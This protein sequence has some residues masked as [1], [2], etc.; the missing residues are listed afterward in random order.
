M[1]LQMARTAGFRCDV[2]WIDG[3]VAVRGEFADRRVMASIRRACTASVSQLSI[4]VAAVK[5]FI[6]F[7]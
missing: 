6:T 2:Q 3:P 4:Y 1:F 5:K 7:E